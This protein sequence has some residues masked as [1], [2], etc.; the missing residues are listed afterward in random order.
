MPNDKEEK[1]KESQ[2]GS[3]HSR[4]NLRCVQSKYFDLLDRLAEAKRA[5]HGKFAAG[6]RRPTTDEINHRTPWRGLDGLPAQVAQ[7]VKK[8]RE[9]MSMS[10]VLMETYRDV[11][12]PAPD[13]RRKSNMFRQLMIPKGTRFWYDETHNQLFDLNFKYF[14]PSADPVFNRLIAG[15]V[16]VDDVHARLETAKENPIQILER[17]IVAGKITLNDINEKYNQ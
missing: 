8:N 10:S 2:D 1:N 15:S 12:N 14:A 16:V 5:K 4:A 9:R 3:H 13:A 17:L 7:A 11:E 6:E